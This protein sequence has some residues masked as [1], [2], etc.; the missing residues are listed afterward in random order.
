MKT[1]GGADGADM[2]VSR[3][4]RLSV[5]QRSYKARHRKIDT[6]TIQ[7]ADGELLLVVSSVSVKVM[8]TPHNNIH[9]ALFSDD[10]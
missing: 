9:I 2:I 3:R 8:H 6:T 10:K 4:W 7:V 1:I 5:G